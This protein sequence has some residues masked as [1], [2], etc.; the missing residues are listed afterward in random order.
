MRTQ[1]TS[2][3]LIELLV[4]VAIIALLIAILIPA[5]GA[6]R[7]HARALK[8]QTNLS[9]LMKGFLMFA[10]DHNDTLPGHT[11]TSDEA[12]LW[13]T[14]WLWGQGPWRD[15][16]F[17]FPN[18]PEK[19]TLFIYVGKLTEIYRCPSQPKGE[20][21]SGIGSNGR[22]DYSM[23]QILP[24]ALTN[25]LNPTSRFKNAD[26]TYQGGL[27]T[28]VLVEEEP[29]YYLNNGN[30]EGAHGGIDKMSHIHGGGSYYTSL[31]G[32]VHFFTQ[33]WDTQ[34]DH[35]ELETMQGRWVSDDGWSTWG[36]WNQQ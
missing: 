2:F 1:R 30:I 6:A 15:Y 21:N 33:P 36:Y 23:I 11:D 26:G 5:L 19:G 20:L 10:N 3:T 8:C 24:G 14:S 35:W 34:A 31:D 4:V 29:G 7:S 22:F 18:A 9:G 12:E 32:S 16:A 28:P 27:A 25:K 17:G 13:K